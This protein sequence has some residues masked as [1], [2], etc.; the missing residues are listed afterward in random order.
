MSGQ[1]WPA[2][3]S[4]DL[5]YSPA[6]ICE[7]ETERSLSPSANPSERQDRD[8][9]K[10]KTARRLVPCA[11]VTKLRAAGSVAVDYFFLSRAPI[12]RMPYMCACCA[13]PTTPA[14]QHGSFSAVSPPQKNDSCPARQE[15]LVAATT[16]KLSQGFRSRAGAWFSSSGMATCV[17][18]F[19]ALASMDEPAVGQTSHSDL[20]C[21]GL[22][23]SECID[24]IQGSSVAIAVLSGIPDDAA[25]PGFRW[26]YLE[27]GIFFIEISSIS[28]FKKNK[29][30][31]QESESA[32]KDLKEKW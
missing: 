22:L 25:F 12:H 19:Q 15:E 30:Q 28:D 2:G 23:C 11:V 7:S 31:E 26:D 13:A 17:H 29:T 27:R 5:L 4:S 21:R 24:P 14:A 32:T 16:T 10:D 1:S 6:L 8:F 20:N 9:S 18:D 3:G